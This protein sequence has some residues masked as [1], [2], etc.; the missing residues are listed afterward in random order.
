MNWCR[1]LSYTV[2]VMLFLQTGKTHYMTNEW[3]AAEMIVYPAF[4]F[5]LE[6]LLLMEHR[7]TT[8]LLFA[9][10][11]Q[12]MDIYAIKVVIRQH[13]TRHVMAKLL[14][15]QIGFASLCGLLIPNTLLKIPG[16]TRDEELRSIRCTATFVT[17]SI[18]LE[19]AFTKYDSKNMGTFFSTVGLPIIV[20]VLILFL[21]S[22][23]LHQERTSMHERNTIN[24]FMS[25]L[26]LLA[27]V[28][29]LGPNTMQLNVQI[30]T[31]Y[32]GTSV[33]I[34]T[35]MTMLTNLHMNMIL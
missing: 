10:L 8:M 1:I 31:K 9:R 35:S 27:T 12:L 5:L 13:M 26:G 7:W 25:G 15:A 16:K 4:V 29:L 30:I 22:K 34:F 32:I 24:I 3:D 20:L 21:I 23:Q 14:T 2:I 11:A 28:N 18:L 17:L 33:Y 19:A 6:A